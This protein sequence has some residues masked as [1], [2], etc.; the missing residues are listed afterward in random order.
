[1]IFIDNFEKR[2][3]DKNRRSL[4]VSDLLFCKNG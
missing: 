2:K 4:A 3:L 1:M